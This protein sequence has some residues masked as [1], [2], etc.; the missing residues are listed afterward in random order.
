GDAGSCLGVVNWGSYS[1][2]LSNHVHNIPTPTS[3]CGANGGAAVDHANYMGGNNDTIGNVIHDVG[4]FPV[5]DDR[6]H[7]IYHSNYGGLVANNIVY[8]CAGPGIDLSHAPDHVTVANNTVFNNIHA[9]IYIA[10]DSGGTHIN[11]VNNISVHNSGWGIVEPNGYIPP[12]AG[13]MYV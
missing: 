1:R 8:R 2:I 12:N 9:G 11:V 7:G 10:E 13:N 5:E 4:S 3:V 6:A